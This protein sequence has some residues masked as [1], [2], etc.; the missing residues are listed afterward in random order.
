[1]KRTILVTIGIWGMLTGLYAVTT[2]SSK[3]AL[4]PSGDTYANTFS[5]QLLQFVVFKMP[6]LIALLAAALTTQIFMFRIKRERFN[7]R[8]KNILRVT[9]WAG[10]GFTL[11]IA[12]WHNA[13]ANTPFNPYFQRD[14]QLA[15]E[16]AITLMPICLLLVGLV[17]AAE[18]RWLPRRAS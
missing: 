16:Y 17:L 9:L 1:M 3:L 18:W 6:A 11:L 13:T 10:L 8:A 15:L 12:A 4:P 2:I 14:E 7:S 5:Y